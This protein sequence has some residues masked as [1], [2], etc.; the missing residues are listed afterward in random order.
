MSEGIASKE[1]KH[2]ICL[3]TFQ[4]VN[5]NHILQAVQLPPYGNPATLL[6]TVT[7]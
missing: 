6:L 3:C 1:D 7:H 4:F 5:K 2:S